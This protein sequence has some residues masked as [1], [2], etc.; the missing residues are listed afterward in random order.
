MVTIKDLEAFGDGWNRHDV[1]FIMTFM[2]VDCV[3]ETTAGKEA[4]GTRYEG[5]ERVRE[6]FAK[7]FKR[8]LAV[9]PHGHDGR[10]QEDRSQ[11]LRRVHVRAWQD[12]RQELVLQ[13]PYGVA[14]TRV[15]ACDQRMPSS[16]TSPTT[17][18]T[19][20]RARRTKLNASPAAAPKPS[21]PK[22]AA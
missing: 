13:E 5:R 10:R 6:A 18:H 2:A 3:F 16:T 12:R 1:D 9:A 19:A 7:V 17:I 14:G 20:C 22:V 8:P 21:A 11:R 15:R 4:C